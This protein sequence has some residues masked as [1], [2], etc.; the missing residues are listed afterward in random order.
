MLFQPHAL[1][2]HHRLVDTTRL[3]ARLNGE[4]NISAHFSKACHEDVAAHCAAQLVH[5]AETN[6][7][8]LSGYLHLRPFE[9]R[10]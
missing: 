8:A 9:S 4:N 1:L 3:C 7:N 5:I 6:T 2:L 10:E